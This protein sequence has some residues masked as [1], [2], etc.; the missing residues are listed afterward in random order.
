[1]RSRVRVSC[2][3]GSLQD[4]SRRLKSSASRPARGT[5]EIELRPSSFSST[6][7]GPFSTGSARI[8][9]PAGR[10]SYRCSSGSTLLSKT[11]WGA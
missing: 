6:R 2:G 1:M 8:L 11:G 3:R 9:G 10:R 7:F 5:S 4:F